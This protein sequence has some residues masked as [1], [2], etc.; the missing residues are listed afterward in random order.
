MSKQ[1]PD[2]SVI[3]WSDGAALERVRRGCWPDGELQ[4][5]QQQPTD[6]E[7]Q[8]DAEPE[9]CSLA[10]SSARPIAFE[11]MPPTQ[12]AGSSHT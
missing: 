7:L 10:R 11:R 12:L 4:L 9:S 5:V 3:L 2:S 1:F 8:D 6:A